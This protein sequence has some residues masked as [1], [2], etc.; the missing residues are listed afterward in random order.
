SLWKE[1]GSTFGKT[2]TLVVWSRLDRIMWKT[3]GAIIENSEFLIGRMYRKF[4]E[5]GNVKIRMVSFDI[6]DITSSLHEEY[7]QPNDP[8]YLMSDTSCPA[9]FDSTPMF[10]PW[11][12]EDYER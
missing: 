12:D 8:C 7:A 1:V 5:N 6:D 4:L 2:G 10:Q 11:G 3:A 9:P